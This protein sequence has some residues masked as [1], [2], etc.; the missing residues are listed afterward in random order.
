MAL[1]VATDGSEKC[2]PPARAVHDGDHYFARPVFLSRP[3]GERVVSTLELLKLMK[4]TA[5]DFE[6]A[7]EQ[8]K[9]HIEQVARSMDSIK[10]VVVERD[11]MGTSFSHSQNHLSSSCAQT[12]SNERSNTPPTTH[13]HKQQVR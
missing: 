10:G 6:Q 2:E 11:T 12:R 5:V 8:V 3:I 1:G 13:T 4:E 7:G 9:S